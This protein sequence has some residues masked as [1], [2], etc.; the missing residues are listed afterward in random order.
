[1][2]TLWLQAV[3]VRRRQEH[4][5]PPMRLAFRAL[6]AEAGN[7]A[8]AKRRACRSGRVGKRFFA[9][10]KV[11]RTLEQASQLR[12]RMFRVQG[13]PRSQF[14]GDVEFLPEVQHAHR[15]AKLQNNDEL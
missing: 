4:D 2:S 6:G 8:A 7:P 3:G 14:R 11:R 9:P 1:M 5:V 10:A 15:S 12:D 13:A